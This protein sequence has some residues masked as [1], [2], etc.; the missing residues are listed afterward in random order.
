[1]VPASVRNRLRETAGLWQGRNITPEG[2]VEESSSPPGS[3]EA[4]RQTDREADRQADRDT[5]TKRHTER[6][7]VDSDLFPFSEVPH[8][9]SALN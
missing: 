6:Q 3:L 9:S 5:E 7:G 4:E 2:T 8:P 1:M